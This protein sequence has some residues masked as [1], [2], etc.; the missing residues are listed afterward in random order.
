MVGWV[1]RP[2]LRR[3]FSFYQNAPRGAC[4]DRFYDAIVQNRGM[5][6]AVAMVGNV[7]DARRALYDRRFKNLHPEAKRS[8]WFFRRVHLIN[9]VIYKVNARDNCNESE[10]E[11]YLRVMS[12]SD[13]LPDYVRLPE[14]NKY[15][16]DGQV[17]IAAEYIKG[18]HPSYDDV[19][20]L[21]HDLSCSLDLLDLHDENIILSNGIYYIIDLDS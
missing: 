5:V 14:M 16:V 12:I 18:I 8:G 9:G 1:G 15:V 17:I 2:P 10:W 13:V 7:T 6:Y 20:S 3:G 19:D 4:L 21:L 11:N